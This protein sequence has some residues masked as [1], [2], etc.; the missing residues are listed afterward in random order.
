MVEDDAECDCEYLASSDDERNKMLF[1]LLDHSVDKHLSDGR[2]SSHDAH[3]KQE[4][5]VSDYECAH[6]EELS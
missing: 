2:K 6:R 5:P 3:M 4:H 1:E